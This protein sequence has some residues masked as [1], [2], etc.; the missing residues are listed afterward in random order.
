MRIPIL[1]TSTVIYNN[2]TNTVK[3]NIIKPTSNA[4][5][6]IITPS[7]FNDNIDKSRRILD[8]FK[9][10]YTDIINNTNNNKFYNSILFAKN[11]GYSGFLCFDDDLDLINDIAK[12]TVLPIIYVGPNRDITGSIGNPIIIFDNYSVINATILM[13]QI[14][15]IKYNNIQKKLEEMRNST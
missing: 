3:P 9:I 13:V 10:N 11:D 15:S 2:T 4:K 12:H 1:K 14:L 5:I 6:M 8:L 7:K